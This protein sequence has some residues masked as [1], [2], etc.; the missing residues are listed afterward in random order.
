MRCGR[1]KAT[2]VDVPHVRACYSGHVP[3]PT[4][5]VAAPRPKKIPSHRAAVTADA[6][7]EVDEDWAD[8]FGDD[9]EEERNDPWAED[10]RSAAAMGLDVMGMDADGRSA[11]MRAV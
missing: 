5:A 7:M 9:S 1:C 2:D 10:R 4:P 8:L 6:K 3:V 11:W